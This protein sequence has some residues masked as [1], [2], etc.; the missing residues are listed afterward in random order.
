MQ[1]NKNC[2]DNTRQTPTVQEARETK[3]KPA[4]NHMLC[5]GAFTT[6]LVLELQVDLKVMILIFNNSLKYLPDVL[7][8]MVSPGDLFL[9]LVSETL[10]QWNNSGCMAT[11][12]AILE[13]LRILI[14]SGRTESCTQS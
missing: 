12:T 3:H 13:E 14:K 6:S 11:C 7:Y 8:S 4:Q 2:N 1:C 9:N 10:L 5:N